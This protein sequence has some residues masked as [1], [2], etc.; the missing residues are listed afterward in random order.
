[1]VP[2]IQLT[3][4]AA[5]NDSQR[6]HAEMLPRSAV[7]MMRKTRSGIATTN[8]NSD[9]ASPLVRPRS[10]VHATAA[11]MPIR[12]NTGSTMPRISRMNLPQSR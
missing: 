6:R 3:A 10:F 12:P 7:A 8:T 4:K 5:K 11:P 1:M 2:A 9:S